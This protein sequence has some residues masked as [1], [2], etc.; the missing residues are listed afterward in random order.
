MLSTEQKV[1]DIFQQFRMAPTALDEFETKGKQVLTD[2]L[3]GFIGA[4]KTIQFVMLGFPFKSTNSRDKVLGTKPDL[5]EQVTMENFAH[6]NSLVKE[7]YEPGIQLTMA[8]DGYAFNNILGVPDKV[9]E[10]YQEIS[11]DMNGSGPVKFFNLKDAYS[12]TSDTARQKMFDHFGI[13]WVELERRILFDTDMNILYRGMIRFMEEELAI[14]EHPSRNQ[15]NKA[16]KLLTREM[17]LANEAYS[18]LV[19]KEF[20]DSIRL[21]MH[22]SINSGKKFSFQLI[23]GENVRHSAWHACLFVNQEGAYETIHKKDALAKGLQLVY[24]DGQPYNFTF[25]F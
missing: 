4:G 5:A 1:L 19:T 23:P 12:S 11:M 7:V 22:P 2:K 16:A 24:K 20:S 6:F 3:T 14:K 13:S 21:S 9:V 17:M 8:S 10:E 18:Q 25:N 15:L